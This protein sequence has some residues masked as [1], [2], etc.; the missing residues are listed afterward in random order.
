MTQP[1]IHFH[2]GTL[3]QSPSPNL[4][5]FWKCFLGIY[6]SAKTQGPLYFS[7][8]CK[9][10]AQCSNW[11]WNEK[12][13]DSL[14]WVLWKH[15]VGSLL[16]RSLKESGDKFNSHCTILQK[17]DTTFYYLPQICQRK[18]W[19]TL[20]TIIAR[21]SSKQYSGSIPSLCYWGR[22]RECW[23]KMG[24]KHRMGPH[25][26]TWLFTGPWT[27]STHLK[28]TSE[29]EWLLFGGM[30]NI[31]LKFF[32]ILRSPPFSAQQYHLH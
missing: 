9:C 15:A 3:S 18:K 12:M 13:P 25:M 14:L 23:W 10:L 2:L 19:K 27:A 30:W 32:K 5:A 31:V 6:S 8:Y 4:E 29:S 7:L 20:F 17:T 28:D 16:W 11:F 1:I 24:M 22:L 21:T 26:L